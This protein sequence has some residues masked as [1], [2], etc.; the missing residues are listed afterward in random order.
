MD[1]G[2]VE[3]SSKGVL[4]ERTAVAGNDPDKEE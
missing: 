1:Q 4:G 3:A 2:N